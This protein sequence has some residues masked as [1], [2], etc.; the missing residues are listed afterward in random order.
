MR[1]EQAAT[2][3]ELTDTTLS[4]IRLAGVLFFTNKPPTFR[5]GA[6]STARDRRP[7]PCLNAELHEHQLPNHTANGNDIALWV[8]R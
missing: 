7:R 2:F 8:I 4:L 3:F 5:L 1:I 6:N